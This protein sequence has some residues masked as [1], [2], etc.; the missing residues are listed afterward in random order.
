MSVCERDYQLAAAA[1]QSP[2]TLDERVLQ[3][4][5]SFRATRQK[6]PWVSKAASG[7]AAFAIAVLLIHPAQYLGAL[8]PSG[9]SHPV[10]TS[11]EIKALASWQEYAGE[12]LARTD[13]WFELRQTVKT[14]DHVALCSHWREQKRGTTAEKL[15]ADLAQE[16]RRHCR[17]L[18]L[19]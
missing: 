12:A 10:T 15:P 7:C 17:V 2:H 3:Q 19:R 6:Y 14:G 13:P 8:T 16:A 4:A 1:M 18:Q 9:T 11:S 5:R